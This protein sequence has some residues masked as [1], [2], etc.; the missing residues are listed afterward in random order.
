MS[1]K[2]GLGKGLGKGLDSLIPVNDMVSET[3]AE[4]VV[5]VV[6]KSTLAVIDTI[7]C[8]LEI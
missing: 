1:K 8:T 6:E 7:D 3:S 4:K 5:E 2:G